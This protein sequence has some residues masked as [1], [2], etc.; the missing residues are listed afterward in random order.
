MQYHMP[1]Q[2]FLQHNQSGMAAVTQVFKKETNH[3]DHRQLVYNTAS[4]SCFFFCTLFPFFLPH[5]PFSAMVSFLHDAGHIFFLQI[6]F[7]VLQ[8][9]IQSD[10]HSGHY[11]L[12]VLNLHNKRFEVLD[13]MRNLENGKLAEC[14]N[15]ITIAIKSLW[16][17][18]Y[19]NTKN[20]IDKYKIVDIP[21]PKQT[22]K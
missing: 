21:I 13:S 17:I 4:I 9:L 3:L 12:I 1:M 6:L 16:K 7:P 15:K 14:C 8:K 22:N 5:L 10:E 19:P 18:Y 11:F 2:T 20:P